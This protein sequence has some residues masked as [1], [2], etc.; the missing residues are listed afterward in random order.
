MKLLVPLI[1]FITTFMNVSADT[2]TDAHGTSVLYRSFEPTGLEEG[3]TY[4]LVLF[5]HGSGERG[6]D[7]VSQIKNGVTDFLEIAETLGEKTFLVAPQCPQNIW[8]SQPNGDLTGL[9]D[10][11]GTN[12]LLDA[13]HALVDR[14]KSELPIDPN[15]IYLTGLSMGGFG[16]FALLAKYPETWAAA[17]PICGGGAP[18]TAERF[19][20]VPLRIIHGSADKIVPP[21][22]SQQMAAALETAGA[23]DMKLIIYPGVGHDSWTQTYRD[24]ELIRWLFQQRKPQ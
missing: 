7:N 22:G 9:Q 10:A 17:M 15:R 6:N 21:K 19:R 18:E 14:L 1:A 12:P 11:L 23:T 20:N 5:L 4:P 13:V 2:F 8:W 24:K 3:K 16:S